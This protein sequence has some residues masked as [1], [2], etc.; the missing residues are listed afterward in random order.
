MSPRRSPTLADAL[1]GNLRRL[2]AHHNLSQL[3]LSKLTGVG[4]STISGLASEGSQ[5]EPNPRADTIDALARYFGVPAWLLAIPDLP[6]EVLT[7][8]ELATIIEHVVAASPTGRAVIARVAESEVQRPR[9]E[10]RAKR[11]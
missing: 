7:S 9:E 2:M 1:G 6:I 4:Q 11:A 3:A 8:R 10:Q 5:A